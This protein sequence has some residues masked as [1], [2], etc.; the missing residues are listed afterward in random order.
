MTLADQEK[1]ALRKII[2]ERL[3]EFAAQ[4]KM[5]KESS[6]VVELDQAL[7]GRVSR[8]DAIQ[9]QKIAEAGLMRAQLKYNQLKKALVNLSSD[10]YG[11]CVEC[12]EQIGLP[13]L[14]IKP[15]STLCIECQ[16]QQEK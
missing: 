12:G 7:A 16:S 11:S 13:R 3:S 2:E 6:Q 10:D 14:L 15:E 9:Q 5:S 4:L 8:I 1:Q